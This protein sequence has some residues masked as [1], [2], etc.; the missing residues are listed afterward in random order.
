[1]NDASGRRDRQL[2]PQAIHLLRT[3][4]QANMALS[5]MADQ[6]ASLLMGAT[7]VVF[8]LAVGQV[9]REFYSPIMLLLGTFAFFSACLAVAA[10]LPRYGSKPISSSGANILFF[11]VFTEMD[12]ESFID[13]V[14]DRLEQDEDIFRM[15]LR[16]IYQN[17]QVLQRRKYRLMSWS[18][19]VFI[20]GLSLSMVA[21]LIDQR[22]VFT[23]IF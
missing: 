16:D 12:E 11:G 7:F 1:M 23:R 2:S 17:G 15:M 22:E 21:F 3:S 6:K 20:T 9:S 18:Y 4:M 8:T 19:R 10:V 14:L 13:A 5:R